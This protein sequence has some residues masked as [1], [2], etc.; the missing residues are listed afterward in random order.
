MKSLGFGR[1]ALTGCVAAAM[2]AGCGESQP[3]IGAPGTMAQSH[4]MERAGAPGEKRP[5]YMYVTDI[6]DVQVLTYPVES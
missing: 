2:L 4:F 6:A 5:S 3:P 1:Y